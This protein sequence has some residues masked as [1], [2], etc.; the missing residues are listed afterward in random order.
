C[1]AGEHDG[2]LNGKYPHVRNL[3]AG[4]VK[5]VSALP[6]PR[7]QTESEETAPLEHTRRND[8][9]HYGQAKRQSSRSEIVRSPVVHCPEQCDEAESSAEHIGTERS[10]TETLWPSRC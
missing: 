1:D 4:A 9:H 6:D 7:M 3:D 2:Q 10:R 8:S 5:V